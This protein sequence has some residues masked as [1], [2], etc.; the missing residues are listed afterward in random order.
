MYIS[1]H[2]KI[3]GGIKSQIIDHINMLVS[4]SRITQLGGR[5]Q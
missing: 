4:P 5:G 3:R 2:W 1:P